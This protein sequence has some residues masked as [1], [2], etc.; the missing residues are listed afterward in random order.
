[1]LCDALEA[2]GVLD[3]R[4]RAQL[5]A[6]RRYWA[7]ERRICGALG[8]GEEPGADDVAACHESKSFDYR[9]LHCVLHRLLGARWR[10]SCARPR[11]AHGRLCRRQV[12]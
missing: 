12:R 3:E 10:C 1:V 2:R 11:S 6:G 5:E 9:V 7:L 8:R 4:I